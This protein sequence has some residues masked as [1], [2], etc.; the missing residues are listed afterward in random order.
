M[1]WYGSVQS[2]CDWQVVVHTESCVTHCPLAP[3]CVHTSAAVCPCGHDGAHAGKSATADTTN[4][5]RNT[6]NDISN[7]STK[8][9]SQCPT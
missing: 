7:P 2:T 8:T 1:H 9:A 4:I 6:L 5:H 3:H